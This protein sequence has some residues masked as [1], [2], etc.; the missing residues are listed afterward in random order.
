M[1]SALKAQIGM[2]ETAYQFLAREA[3][4]LGTT[5]ESYLE[6]LIERTAGLKSSYVE[7]YEAF[8]NTPLQ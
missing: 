8:I 2:T 4:A 6:L 5:A 3:E 7:S 1:M